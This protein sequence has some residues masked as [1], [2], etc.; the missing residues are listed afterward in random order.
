MKE[1]LD[2]IFK[3]LEFLIEL[4]KYDIDVMSNAWMYWPLL[5]PATFYFSF[6]MLKWAFLTAPIWIPIMMV[7]G[8]IR[9]R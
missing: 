1:I 2:L 3:T 8:S 5:V 9:I 6:M 4:W 7:R